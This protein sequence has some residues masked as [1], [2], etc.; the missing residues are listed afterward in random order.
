MCETD[1]FFES[2]RLSKHIGEEI[3]KLKSHISIKILEFII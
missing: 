3:D 2:Y 1:K